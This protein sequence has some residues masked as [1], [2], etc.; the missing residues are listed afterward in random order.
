MGAAARHR[1][2]RGRG[3]AAAVGAVP[4]TGWRAEGK[5]LTTKT[6]RLKG[7]RGVG[8]KPDRSKCPAKMGDRPNDRLAHHPFSQIASLISVV[9]WQLPCGRA[10]SGASPPAF[11]LL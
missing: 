4:G 5:N 1:R 6:R 8:R 2:V 3:F 9:T 7:F 10:T 11:C